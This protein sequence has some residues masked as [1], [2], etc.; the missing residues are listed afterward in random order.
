MR[1]LLQV[2]MVHVQQHEFTTTLKSRFTIMTIAYC[3]FFQHHQLSLFRLFCIVK[4]DK[5]VVVDRIETI[6]VLYRQSS[7]VNR[8]LGYRHNFE[9]CLKYM[10]IHGYMHDVLLCIIAHYC[11]TLYTLLFY[12]LHIIVPN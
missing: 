10:Q 2:C 8:Q 7:I 5:T 1:N 9:P 4:M 11:S 6:S 12:T 3:F